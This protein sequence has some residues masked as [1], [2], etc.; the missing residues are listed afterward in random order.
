MIS[1]VASSIAGTFGSSETS[2]K[3]VRLAKNRS[4]HSFFSQ[5]NVANASAQSGTTEVL[6]KDI[7]Y[8]QIE[9]EEEDSNGAKHTH[10]K[11]FSAPIGANVVAQTTIARKANWAKFDSAS[12]TT[13]Y[14]PIWAA[15]TPECMLCAHSFRYMA[16]RHHCRYVSPHPAVPWLL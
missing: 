12:T 10:R 4:A 8:E 14:A 11:A 7:I 5:T 16:R 1:S 15:D 2:N 9:E 13:I 3:N 6:G